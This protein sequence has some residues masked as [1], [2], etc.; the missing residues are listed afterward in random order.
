MFFLLYE[1]RHRPKKTAFSEYPAGKV[2]IYYVPSAYLSSRMSSVADSITRNVSE[3]EKAI[4]IPMKS[5]VKVY[6][7]NNWEEKGNDV[8]WISSAHCD[9][10]E[11]AIY[12]IVNEKMDGTLEGLAYALLLQERYGPPAR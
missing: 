11:H 2:K 1:L 10:A 9:P 5:A 12:Y 8:R 7:Y 4:G 3:A 6:L